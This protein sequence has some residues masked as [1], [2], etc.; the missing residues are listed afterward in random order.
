VADAA[1]DG[2]R[3]RGPFASYKHFAP[4]GLEFLNPLSTTPPH[5]PS[6]KTTIKR[7]DVRPLSIKQPG[8]KN[9]SKL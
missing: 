9:F 7:A 8:L 1:P 3:E 5:P 6:L 2:A 4:L